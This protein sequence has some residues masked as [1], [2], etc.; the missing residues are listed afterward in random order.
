MTL[1]FLGAESEQHEYKV[2]MEGDLMQLQTLGWSDVGKTSPLAPLPSRWPN[3]PK[4][5]VKF[6]WAYPLADG[7]KDGTANKAHGCHAFFKL[8]SSSELSFVVRGGF[9]LLSETNK[10]VQ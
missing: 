1:T 6:C 9:L 8:G 4:Q 5:A 2:K 3:A 10:V 7:E